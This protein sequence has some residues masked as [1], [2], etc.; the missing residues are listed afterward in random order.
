MRYTP[1]TPQAS[2]NFLYKKSKK[3]SGMKRAAP[4]RAR[5]L[6]TGRSIANLE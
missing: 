1:Q 4:E 6:L 3:E 2:T 5:F